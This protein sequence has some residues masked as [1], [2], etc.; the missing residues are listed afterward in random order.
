MAV[1]SLK[2]A[3]KLAGVSR[4]TLYRKK[5][6]GALSVTARDDGSLGVDTA[7]LQRVFGALKAEDKA[8]AAPPPQE[9]TGPTVGEL[10]AL[11]TA[12]KLSQEA[13]AAATEREKKLLE[14]V[15]RQTRLL[16]HKPPLD[17]KPKDIDR[18]PKRR[19]RKYLR[20]LLERE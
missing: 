16:E 3:A 14:I 8:P 5:K 17:L 13:L 1:I 9:A 19:L 15:D 20:S 6:E 7:E 11:K 2:E 10:E 4:Q 12:L 18:A